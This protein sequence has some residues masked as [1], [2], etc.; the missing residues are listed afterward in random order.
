[1]YKPDTSE[2][3]DKLRKCWEKRAQDEGCSKASVLF[4]GLP[5][6]LNQYI[7]N[8]HKEIL[9]AHCLPKIK[10]GASVLDLGCSYGRIT[11]IIKQYM[12]NVKIT[13]LDFSYHYCALYQTQTGC[14]AVCADLKSIPFSDHSF[15]CIIAI[16][17]LMY[18]HTDERDRVMNNIETLL[19]PGG[20]GFF[21]DPG[22]EYMNIVNLI[23][24]S[25]KKK[26]TGGT[27]FTSKEYNRLGHTGNLEIINHGGMTFFSLAT[28]LLLLI[29]RFNFLLK[30]I[31][32]STYWLDLTFHTYRFLSLHKW[33]L[34]KKKTY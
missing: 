23:N 14:S 8:F 1:M 12:D 13:G 31:L 32:K 16:T 27:G 26:S 5:E 29:K 4:R 28:P 21:L 34:V 30:I 9:Q 7:H 17:S 3:N 2:N 11:D 33:M 20:I 24:P 10:N 6:S 15:D 19:K 25:R 22:L 18:V